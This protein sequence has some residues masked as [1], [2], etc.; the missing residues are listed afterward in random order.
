MLR[1]YQAFGAKYAIA[2]RHTLI[3]D[4]M[5]LGKTVEAIAAM[6][7]LKAEGTRYF[8]VVCPASVLI[9][10]CRVSGCFRKGFRRVEDSDE[11]R[12]G[13]AALT[14][15]ARMQFEEM[16]ALLKYCELD[17]LVQHKD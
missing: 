5:G 14:A 16:K 6:A 4:E 13:G 9:N 11:L 8:A 7:H 12:D 10:W 3:G 2:Q 15:Y 1:G 17:T